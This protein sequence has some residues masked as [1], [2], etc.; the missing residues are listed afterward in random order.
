MVELADNGPLHNCPKA[1]DHVRRAIKGSEEIALG[2]DSRV[3]DAAMCHELVK[4]IVE[5]TDRRN[6]VDQGKASVLKSSVA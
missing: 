3:V 4:P 2:I 1:L 6:P 5:R